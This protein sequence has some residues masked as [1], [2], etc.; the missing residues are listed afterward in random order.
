MEVT[1]KGTAE[2]LAS[3]QERQVEV[4]VQGPVFYET[5]GTSNETE[6]ITTDEWCGKEI[7]CL[8]KWIKQAG[9]SNARPEEIRTLPNVAKQLVKLLDF[10]W[11]HKETYTVAMQSFRTAR[12]EMISALLRFI[13]RVTKKQDA[14][15]EE[16][17]A[18]PDV[19]SITNQWLFYDD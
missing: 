6:D 18:L 10:L 3:L 11:E 9:A 14:T 19:V 13:E 1:L 15:S 4:S 17:V 2:E 8:A 12:D 5:D 7:L 16:L